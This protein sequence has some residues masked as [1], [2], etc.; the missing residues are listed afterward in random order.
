MNDDSSAD[1]SPVSNAIKP[2]IINEKITE[3]PASPAATPKSTK[4]PVPMIAPI[5]ILAVPHT[6]RLRF[7]S[8]N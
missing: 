4:I 2:A 8:V 6:P 7:N 3:G 5:P 1:E